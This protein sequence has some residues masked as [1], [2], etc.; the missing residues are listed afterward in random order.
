LHR[1]ETPRPVLPEETVWDFFVDILSG[2][3]Y[4]HDM[5]IVHRD[6]K[7]ENIL[8]MQVSLNP[9]PTNI[10]ITQV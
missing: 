6:I 2:V 3:R 9:K 8:I 10:P 4:L 5:G 7:P 1:S